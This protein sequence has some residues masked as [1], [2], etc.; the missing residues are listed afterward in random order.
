MTQTQISIIRALQDGLELSEEPFA[1]VAQRA[2][3]C[4]E[5][6]LAQLEEWRADGT[7]RRFGAILRH[8]RAG[9]ESNA[10]GVWDVPEDK[11]ESF[12][13]AAGVQRSVSHCYQRPRFDDFPYNLYT[14]IHGKCRED[15]EAV[16]RDIAHQTGV[17]AY[18]LLYTTA[19]FKKS[20]PIYFP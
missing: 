11:I 3:V 1:Q 7:I 5:D 14:M 19:E 9:Y 10:M 15:C 17:S 12:A 8:R 13:S 6:L 2:G 18:T 4:L 20:S 16:A